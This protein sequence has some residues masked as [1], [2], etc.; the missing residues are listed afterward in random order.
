MKI[1]LLNNLYPPF[2][3]GSGAEVITQIMHQELKKM[4][5]E[6]VVIACRPYGAEAPDDQEVRYLASLYPSL[7]KLPVA[8]RFLWHASH[9]LAWVK[10]WRLRRIIA[11]EKCDLVI[12]HNLEGLS[13]LISRGLKVKHIHILHDIQLLHPSGL[14]YYGQ[15]QI[16]E[17]PWAKLYQKACRWGLGQPHLIV[18]PSTWLMKLHKSHGFC[19]HSQTLVLKNPQ[20]EIKQAPA[21]KTTTAKQPLTFLSV[22]QVDY[23]KGV[24]VLVK[25]FNELLSQ[26]KLDCQLLIVGGGGLL[27]EL[28]EASAEHADRIKFLGKVSNEE[29][30]HIMQTADCLVAPSLCYEN[31][32]TIIFEALAN[33]LPVL[34]SR[35]GGI[36][37]ILNNNPQLLF[38]PNNQ[39]ELLAR[40][41]W[42]ATKTEDFRQEFAQIKNG[43]KPLNVAEYLETL[44]KKAN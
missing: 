11:Q 22:G 29:V 26:D 2:H 28:K 36:P 5:H 34:A 42:V 43:F 14:M 41:R 17:T 44:T 4:G 13:F 6:V 7:G 35:I 27:E 31:S 8:L 33:D 10:A 20:K 25:A 37:E 16:L 39:D 18:S 3:R 15:E 12:S 24:P 19:R 1:C 21:T 40:L 9:S 30:H 23:H 38:E 32:P